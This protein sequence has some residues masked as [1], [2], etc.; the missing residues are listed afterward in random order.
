MDGRRKRDDD[1]DNRLDQSDGGDFEDSITVDGLGSTSGGSMERVAS[2]DEIGLT[3]RLT[4]IIVDRGDG[5]LLLQQSIREGRVLQCLQA[6]NMQVVGACRADE[7]LMPLLKLNAPSSPSED[8]LL[9]HLSQVRNLLI[10]NHFVSFG[11]SVNRLST[12]EVQYHFFISSILA[13]RPDCV[14][15]A[16][17][18]GT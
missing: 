9:D 17:G 4:E 6:L 16:S 18:R 7:R 14:D 8:R 5:D 10:K 1:I 3:E 12:M 13:I 11:S 15:C 2:T